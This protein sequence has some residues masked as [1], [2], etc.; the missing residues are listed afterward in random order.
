MEI[1]HE[2]KQKKERKNIYLLEFNFFLLLLKF[3]L[4]V[5]VIDFFYN[6]DKRTFEK[7]FIRKNHKK[8][9]GK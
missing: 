1:I 9:F 7:L 3:M 6:K 5:N 4:T 2:N 8:K